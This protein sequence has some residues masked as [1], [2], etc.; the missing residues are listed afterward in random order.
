MRA[1][2]LKALD[3]EDLVSLRVGQCRQAG[4]FLVK[5][6]DD[7]EQQIPLLHLLPLP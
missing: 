3:G 5:N 4:L 1:V 7:V 2:P 6:W